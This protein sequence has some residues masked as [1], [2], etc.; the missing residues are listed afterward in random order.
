MSEGGGACGERVLRRGAGHLLSMDSGKRP[1]M[2]ACV[3]ASAGLRDRDYASGGFD[4]R[5][6][7][8]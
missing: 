2:R 8:S 1:A 5:S 7:S 3:V 6:T 4:R